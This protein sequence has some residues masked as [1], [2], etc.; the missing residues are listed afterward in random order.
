MR[1][2]EQLRS[3]PSILVDCLEKQQPLE[4]P[5]PLYSLESAKDKIFEL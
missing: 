4:Q 3:V 5:P 2:K 1:Q